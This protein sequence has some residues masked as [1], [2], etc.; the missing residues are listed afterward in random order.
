LT[1][2]RGEVFDLGYQR[3]EGPRE[4]RMRARKALWLNGVRTSLGLG[5]G[6]RAKIL[7]VLLFVSVMAPALIIVMIAS[8]VGI[9]DDLPGHAGYYLIVSILLLL[10]SAIIAPELLCA[11]RR[12]RV[13]HLYLVRPLTPDDYVA[14]RWLAFFTITLA[15][16]YSGQVILF[17][18][19]TF[20][21]D[22]PLQYL[23]DNWLDVPRFLGAGL[24]VAVFTTTIPLAVASFTARRAYATG[25]VIGLFVISGTAAAILTDCGEEDFQVLDTGRGPQAEQVSMECEP[26]TGD[27]A[28]WF[29]MINLGAMPIAVSD[30]ILGE[31]GTSELSTTLAELPRAAPIAWYLALTVGPA[32][33]LLWRY[34]RVEI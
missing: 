2:R 7:P 19:F 30:M 6:A 22:E 5:R 3:Y 34:R 4:G 24:V 9:T 13:L 1:E 20:A 28:K 32:L 33:L 10:F 8:V 17:A 31:E 11:D 29:A 14:G 25:F 21:A 15:L 26:L 27:H 12:D 23:R 18:G 16:V